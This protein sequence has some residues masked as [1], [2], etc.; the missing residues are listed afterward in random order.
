MHLLELFFLVDCALR[1]LIS[2]SLV[3]EKRLANQGQIL[4]LILLKSRVESRELILE[5]E[6]PS[7]ECP[8]CKNG[9]EKYQAI[10]LGVFFVSL[11][12]C[13]TLWIVAIPIGLVLLGIS[14]MKCKEC[15]LA[16]RQS[17]GAGTKLDP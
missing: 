6:I 12:S 7:D 13:G 8:Q 16:K 17:R 14:M 1:P 5:P 10:G 9:R 2:R 3:V 4:R 15:R 11:F